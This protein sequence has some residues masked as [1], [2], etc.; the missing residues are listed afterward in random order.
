MTMYDDKDNDDH[1][2]NDSDNEHDLLTGLH[3]KIPNSFRSLRT[4][5]TFLSKTCYFLQLP[6]VSAAAINLVKIIL[7]KGS[8]LVTNWVAGSSL[9]LVNSF[10]RRF[11]E[12]SPCW[13][14]SS[15]G[16]V[17]RKTIQ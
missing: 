17:G 7:W 12:K 15:E 6:F 10:E 11:E 13:D 1:D 3:E 9:A 4:I 2:N 14:S 16:R 8:P 5:V